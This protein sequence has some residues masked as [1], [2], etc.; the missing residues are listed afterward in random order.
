MFIEIPREIAINDSTKHYRDLSLAEYRDVL[1]TVKAIHK[2]GIGE[3][4]LRLLSEQKTRDDIVSDI[5]QRLA[6]NL[7]PRR[8][9]AARSVSQAQEVSALETMLDQ[10]NKSESAQ[11]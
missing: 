11:R 5:S 1:N 9:R 7:S 3:N 4:K 8:R 2:E 10:L 6:S